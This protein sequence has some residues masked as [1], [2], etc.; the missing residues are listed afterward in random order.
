[1]VILAINPGGGST[2]VAVFSDRRQLFVENIEHPPVLLARYKVVLD[3]YRMRKEAI[4]DSL[5]SHQTDPGTLE[6][7]VSR[8]GPLQ[9]V[10]GGVYRVTPRVIADIRQGRVQTV[11]P[12]LLG[13]LV[14]HE[15]AEE[16]GI[17]AYFVDPESTDEFWPMARVTGLRG[18]NRVA[19]SHALSCRTVATLAAKK[20]GKRYDRCSFVVAHLGTGITVAAHVR[21]RQVDATNANDEGPF[22]PQRVGTLP[23][24]GLI[25]LCFSGRYSER[26][27]LD[28]VQRRGGLVSY[29][30]TDD[31]R[32]VEELVRKGNRLAKVVYA[33][34]VYQIAKHIGA[35]AVVCRGKLD[36]VVLTGG[37]AKSKRLVSELRKW[38]RWLSPRIFVFP[39]EEEMPALALRLLSVLE[40]E[41]RIKSYDKEVALRR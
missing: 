1:M 34:L 29:F 17:D 23:L 18:I 12:S 40:G 15:L 36:G 6:A 10:S 3:Q 8:G 16:L 25:R 20:L 33:A 30:G 28:V 9:P 37:L 35:Y 32:Q 4:L 11:H 7:I 13:P 38:I 21:G 27:I 41:E 19:L 31:L 14:A 26:D 39:G 24:A 2:K 5:K 22:S